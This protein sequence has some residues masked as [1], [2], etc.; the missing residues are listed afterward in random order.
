MQIKLSFLGAAKN[1][2]GSRYCIAVDGKRVLVDCGLYQE[3]EFRNRNWDPFPVPPKEIDALLLTHAHLDHCGLIPKLIH[4][5]FL[6]KIY[7]TSA[8]GEISR[9]VLLDS[10]HLMEEDAEFKKKRHKKEGRTSPY[11]VKP[12]YTTEDAEKSFAHYSHVKYQQRVSVT[13]GIEATFYDAG[14]IFGSSMI[15]ITIARNG[16]KRSIL[17]SGDVGRWDKPI[18][19]DPTFAMDSDYIITESTYGDRIHKDNDDPD[20]MLEKII[21]STIERGGNIIIPSFAIER[22]QELLY[23]LNSLLL[24]KRIPQIPVFVDS[25]MAINVTEV[26]KHHPDLFDEEMSELVG[27]H[28]SPFKFP[29]LTF[30]RTT[31]QSKEINKHKGQAIIIAGSGMCTGGRVKH[32]LVNNISREESTILFV[33]YQAAG[34]LGRLILEKPEE[35]RILGQM[36]PIKAEIAQINGFSGHADRDELLKWLGNVNSSPKRVFVTHGEAEAADAMSKLIH[37]KFNWKTSVP[38]Y[39]E[40]VTL[41]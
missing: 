13:D 1:V 40:Q 38:S 31:N 34:T 9:I 8:T 4:E 19:H 17:F 10:A 11:P 36:Y 39:Q 6:G 32:H 22:S 29:G 41:D 20:I 18:L 26:F 12:L 21:N 37:E 28:E 33:G 14:H 24:E 16:E 2:T 30:S 23:L 15:R 25:P 7:C 3:R 5:G 27:N 35:V